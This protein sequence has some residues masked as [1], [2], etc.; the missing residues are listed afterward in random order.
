MM[1][2]STEDR[3]MMYMLFVKWT[4]WQLKGLFC[5]LTSLHGSVAVKPSESKNCQYRHGVFDMCKHGEVAAV[6]QL[7]KA[8][9]LK[10]IH[11]TFVWCT[12]AVQMNN[13]LHSS[14]RC[15]RWS[16]WNMK[17][18][19]CFHGRRA[20]RLLPHTWF[21]LLKWY[22]S[23]DVRANY[24]VQGATVACTTSWTNKVLPWICLSDERK[25]CS[26]LI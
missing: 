21:I 13:W 10:L 18:D 3:Y 6:V 23:F 11:H 25:E 5:L 16:L 7:Y 1:I 12:E 17:F 9:L 14:P 22:T 24:L 20:K 2:D 4:F 26:L 15:K 8:K 19:R